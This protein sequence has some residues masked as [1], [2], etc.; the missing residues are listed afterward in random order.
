MIAFRGLDALRPGDIAR[1][2]ACGDLDRLAGRRRAF[3]VTRVRILLALQFLRGIVARGRYAFVEVI[4]ARIAARTALRL[5]PLSAAFV[6]ALLAVISA[7]LFGDR[8]IS[9][10]RKALLV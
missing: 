9:R 1:L 4:V 10:G 6:D 7:L 3:A 2:H 5:L 8:I